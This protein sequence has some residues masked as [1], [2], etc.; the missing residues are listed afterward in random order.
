[1]IFMALLIG[2]CNAK[3]SERKVS[4][5]AKNS[6]PQVKQDA[7]AVAYDQAKKTVIETPTPS[8]VLYFIYQKDGDGASSYEIENGSWATYWYG[9]RFEFGGKQYFTG[10][11][12]QTQEKYGNSEEE[13]YPDPDTKA[14]ITQATF[15]LTHPDAD[16]PWSFEGAQRFVGEFGGYEKAN[17]IDQDR[18]PQEY[19]TQDKRMVLAI[20]TWYLASGSRMESY[21]LFLFDPKEILKIEDVRWAYLGNVETGEDNSAACDKQ[22]GGKLRCVKR[23]GE[24]SFVADQDAGLPM[25][26]V[27]MNDKRIAAPGL[28]DEAEVEYRYDASEKQYRQQ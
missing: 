20:P 15:I 13:E 6:N 22:D 2:A 16:K 4:E 12:Q 3:T 18:Q 9:Y 7:P 19:R 17:E 23:T 8:S 21:E 5:A 26:R 28:G 27:A 25:I 11:A 1:M 14:A 24:L 10:F